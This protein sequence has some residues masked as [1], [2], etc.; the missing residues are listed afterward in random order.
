MSL[1]SKNWLWKGLT[2]DFGN[3][4]VDLL[5]FLKANFFSGPCLIVS[6]QPEQHSIE[7]LLICFIVVLMVR[8]LNPKLL[9]QHKTDL[10]QYPLAPTS[11]ANRSTLQLLFSITLFSG[12]YLLTCAKP[13]EQTKTIT[14]SALVKQILQSQKHCNGFTK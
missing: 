3:Q 9:K 12:K 13:L 8:F 10:E 7:H 1:F 4:V 6:G 14:F 2:I 11:S 5:G